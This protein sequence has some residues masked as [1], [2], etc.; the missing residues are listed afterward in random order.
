[1]KRFILVAIIA[2]LLGLS[3]AAWRILGPATAFSND[4]YSLYIRTGMD[5]EQL[6][7][8]IKQDTVVKSPAFFNWVARRMNYPSMMKAGK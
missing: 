8:L 3:F 5:Y 4:S 6:L 1:M 2:I 7:E